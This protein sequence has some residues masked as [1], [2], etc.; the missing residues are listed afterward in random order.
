MEP[1]KTLMS[2][3]EF[4]KHVGRGPS[5]ISNW[6]AAGK[7]TAAALV[8]DGHR[9]EIWAEQALRDLGRT[10]DQP[11]QWRQPRPI[12]APR[13]EAVAVMAEAAIEHADDADRVA[14]MTARTAAAARD[15]DLARRA[16]ADADRA[17]LTVEATRRRLA[18]DEGRFVVATEAAQAWGRELAR[19]TA[20]TE[21]FLFSTLARKLADA[22]G[23]DWKALAVEI[24]DSFRTFRAS[25][26]DAAQAE[27]EE[28]DDAAG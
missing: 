27:L 16:R 26:A 1:I 4:A 17:E 10:L 20:N 2:K 8:G 13:S 3:S 14:P 6:I 12:L 25:A 11:R 22:H 24:R 7:I 19:V 21:L 23:L 15:I 18:L 9:A 5:A 28:V